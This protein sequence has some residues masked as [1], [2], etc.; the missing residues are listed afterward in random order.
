MLD[1]TRN[2]G[3]G[4]NRWSPAACWRLYKRPSPW[5]SIGMATASKPSGSVG[6]GAPWEKTDE[7]V[8]AATSWRNVMLLMETGNFLQ[9]KEGVWSQPAEFLRL[10]QEPL[11][12]MSHHLVI[13]FSIVVGA[14][15]IVMLGLWDDVRGL[16]A[17]WKLLNW[18]NWSRM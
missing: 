9:T 1:I 6:S 12:W 16:S 10:H 14:C 8:R 15:T 13:R 11:G 3:F 5:L 2:G 4:P 7:N 18:P 17:V